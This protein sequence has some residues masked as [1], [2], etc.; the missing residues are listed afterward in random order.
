MSGAP[1]VSATTTLGFACAIGGADIK[2]LDLEEF[3]NGLADLNLV[4]A[5][6]NFEGIGVSFS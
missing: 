5:T 4:G 6:V 2:N 1:G 3:F